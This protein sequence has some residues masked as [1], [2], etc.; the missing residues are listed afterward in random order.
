MHAIL[1]SWRS[2]LARNLGTY[3]AGGTKLPMGLKPS[4]RSGMIAWR[5]LFILQKCTSEPNVFRFSIY[6]FPC[7]SVELSTDH[8]VNVCS[9]IVF[10]TLCKVFH[11]S[12]HP[13]ISLQSSSNS[14]T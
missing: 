13:V 2:I 5:L 12:L 4:R 11:K 8:D 6:C 7:D 14:K 10:K 1:K 3:H 9:E